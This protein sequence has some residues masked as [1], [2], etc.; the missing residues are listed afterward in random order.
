MAPALP[1][2][3]AAGAVPGE[4]ANDTPMWIVAAAGMAFVI[5]GFMIVDP[6]DNYPPLDALKR[7]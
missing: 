1:I 6:H 7:N 4:T 5:A 3:A 2:L